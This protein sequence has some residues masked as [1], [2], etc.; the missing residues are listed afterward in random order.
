MPHIEGRQ[1]ER[2]SPTIYSLAL[3]PLA[4]GRMAERIWHSRMQSLLMKR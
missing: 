1:Y 4:I 3:F 2:I